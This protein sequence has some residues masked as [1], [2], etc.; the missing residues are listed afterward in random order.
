M[1]Y[2]HNF[3]VLMSVYWK[4]D[5]RHLFECLDSLVKQTI[6]SDE[7]ILVEDGPLSEDLKF[8]IEEFRKPLR[9]QS[10]RLKK[11]SGLATALNTGLT[12]CRNEMIAR[13]DSD[14]ICLPNRF[15]LQLNFMQSHSDIAICGGFIQEFKSGL[16]SSPRIRHL[17]LEHSELLKFAKKRCPLSHMSVMFRKSVIESLG[18]YPNVIRAQDFALWTLAMVNGYKIANIPHILVYARTGEN[19]FERRSMQAFIGEYHVFKFQRKINFLST[20][21]FWRNVVTRFI[22]RLAPAWMKKIMYRLVRKKL[23]S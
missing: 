14:D 7:L 21:E 1:S 4:D 8:V 23:T 5:P 10:I 19:F 2:T 16:D 17:P 22:V 11:Q 6:P 12:Y 15:E 9:I 13:M 20:Y 3:S 18:G